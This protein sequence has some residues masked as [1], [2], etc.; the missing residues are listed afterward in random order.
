MQRLWCLM[1][2]LAIV[3]V[4]CGPASGP[5]PV[6]QGGESGQP[7]YGGTFNFREDP[8]PFNF[9]I[10]Y[11]KSNPNDNAMALT[12]DSLLDF[13]MGPAYPYTHWELEPALAERWEVSP[14]AKSF[15][16][17]LRQG[18]KFHNLPPVNGREVTSSDVKF[19]VEYRTRSGEVKDKKLPQGE[20]DY[21]FEGLERIDTPDRYTVA[22][23][24]KD[25]FVP[26]V[27]YAASD[28]N[29][30]MPR[31]VYDAEGHFQDTM[32]G[33][34][35]FYLDRAASQKGTRWVFK[36][37]PDYWETGKPYVDEIRWL[38]IP[39]SSSTYAAFQTKQLDMLWGILSN[40]AREVRKANPNVS[41]EKTLV[42]IAQQL[43]PSMAPERNGPWFA[44]PRILEP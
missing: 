7:K 9:D 33:T 41:T 10:S 24:F 32:I 39:D 27:N 17:K 44:V 35:P 6:S 40:D 12:Y 8:D 20:M 18:A 25:P 11:S 1:A 19:T 37:N 16:F 23:H 3:A 14:D 31:E 2:G 29:Q 38:I 5:A 21:M 22:F 30:I 13:K 15:T 42:P 26:F 28:W 4:A 34:G 36:K 43:Y